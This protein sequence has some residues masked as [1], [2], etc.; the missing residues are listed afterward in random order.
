MN[1]FFVHEEAKEKNKV[2]EFTVTSDDKAKAISIF[3]NL[4]KNT[5]CLGLTFFVTFGELFS[6]IIS[7]KYTVNQ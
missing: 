3:R 4:M 5:I 2:A 1:S 6:I 7:S